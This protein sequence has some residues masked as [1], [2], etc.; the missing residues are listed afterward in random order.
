M[1]QALFPDGGGIFQDDNS[2]IHIAHVVKNWYDEHKYEEEQMEW[3]P[4]S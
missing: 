2:P 4:Q 1:V 3:P